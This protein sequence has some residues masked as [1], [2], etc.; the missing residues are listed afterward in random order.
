M[1]ESRTMN[2]WHRFNWRTFAP[3]LLL[4]FVFVPV[5]LDDIISCFG[6]Y[7]NAN[8]IYKL[9]GVATRP[10]LD[11][12]LMWLVYKNIRWARLVTI[13]LWSVF[14]IFLLWDAY[15]FGMRFVH[16]LWLVHTLISIYVLAMSRSLLSFLPKSHSKRAVRSCP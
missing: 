5:L 1:I 7:I 16:L 13:C 9:H 3:L 15:D 2:S 4:C 12:M 14:L 8:H 10:V 6:E 11:A